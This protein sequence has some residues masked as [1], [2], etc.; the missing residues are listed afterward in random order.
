M[1]SPN[2]GTTAGG[3]LVVISGVGFTGVTIVNF[4]GVGVLPTLVTDNEIRVI[5][6]AHPAG[7][8]HLRITSTGGLSPETAGDDFT[9]VEP[10][11]GFCPEIPL[12]VNDLLYGSP[13]GGFYWDQ[14][15]GQVWTGQRSWHLFAPQPARPAPQPL[16]VNALTYG[17]PGGGFYWD[18]VS[19]QVWTAQRGW[20]LYGAQGC[21]PR[22]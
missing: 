13:G 6:P 19:G 22:P 3:T 15:S 8:V 20:H 16:W 17:S 1:R 10:G 4:G 18:P 11:P 21:I 5:S 2:S 12:W 9:F 7:T 14:V